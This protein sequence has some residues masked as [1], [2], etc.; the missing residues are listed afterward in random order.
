MGLSES[1]DL[2]PG[3]VP[4]IGLAPAPVE[5]GRAIKVKQT[6]GNVVILAHALSVGQPHKPVPITVAIA[7]AAAAKAPRV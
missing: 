3:S 5:R 4:K 7:L 2:V 6:K 1:P